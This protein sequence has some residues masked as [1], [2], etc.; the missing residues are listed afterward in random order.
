MK[1]LV[2]HFPGTDGNVNKKFMVVDYLKNVYDK[3]P[4]Q[5][6]ISQFNDKCTLIYTSSNGYKKDVLLKICIKLFN[7][8]AINTFDYSTDKIYKN[9]TYK[10]IT[11]K[12]LLD[13]DFDKL[14]DYLLYVDSGDVLFNLYLSFEDI[15]NRFNEYNCNILFNC[16]INDFPYTWKYFWKEDDSHY[17][18]EYFEKYNVEGLSDKG[19]YLNSGVY[20]GKKEDIKEFIDLCYSVLIDEEKINHHSDQYIFKKCTNIINKKYNKHFVEIDYNNSL[21]KI[22][23]NEHIKKVIQYIKMKNIIPIDWDIV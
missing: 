9:N 2:K 22:E 3:N 7:I 20:F 10:L 21:F 19:L 14:S 23:Y 6:F 18:K 1:Y 4:N 12:K 8:N 15:L 16:E 13:K 11:F 5:E 17:I